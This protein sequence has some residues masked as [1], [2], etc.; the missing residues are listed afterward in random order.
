MMS[1]TRDSKSNK[2]C[3]DKR[4]GLHADVASGC[5][6]RFTQTHSSKWIN[7]LSDDFYLFFYFVISV[8]DGSHKAISVSGFIK[9][10][11]VSFNDGHY[12]YGGNND[13]WK[14]VTYQQT[15]VNHNQHVVDIACHLFYFYH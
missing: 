14:P 7:Y 1:V 11:I 15:I 13:N 6:V 4:E 8:L 12:L 10:P 2:D 3:R 5:Q 9:R